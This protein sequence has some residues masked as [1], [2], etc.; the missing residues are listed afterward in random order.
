M[1]AESGPGRGSSGALLISG[2]LPTS[3]KAFSFLRGT[4]SHALFIGDHPRANAPDSKAKNRATIEPPIMVTPSQAVIAAIESAL[5]AAPE[6]H[7]LRAHLAELLLKANRPA[8]ALQ[9]ASTVLSAIPDHLGAL[10]A[11]SM[12]ATATGQGD[13]AQRYAR[14]RA[15]LEASNAAPAT[16]AP[17]DSIP[18]SPA[19]K[20]VVNEAS[21][22]EETIVRPP[23]VVPLRAVKGGTAD[24]AWRVE[25]T[26]LKL[27]DVAGLDAV[28]RRLELSLFA[29]LRHADLRRFYGQSIRGGLLLYGPPGCGKTFVARATAGE[30]GAH[31]ITFGLNDV[32][33]MFLGQ[34]EA[35]LHQ[36]FEL[37][38]RHAPCVLF[39]DEID[40]LGRKRSLQRQQPGRNLVNQLL[41]EMD[42]L[43]LNNDG[44]FVLAA[45]N[46]PWDVDTAL[47]RPGRFDR[48]IFVGPPDAAP[49]KEILAFHMRERTAEGLDLRLIAERTEGFSGADLAHL[50]DTAAELAM[51][52]SM[53]SGKIRPIQHKDFVTALKQVRP[54]TRT[55]LE[56]A[57]DYA[58][59]ANEGGAYDDLVAY[60][61]SVRMA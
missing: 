35:K 11:A 13:I 19:P 57:K 49:R 1:S 46:H 47:R 28:K 40:A 44:L 25:K 16:P 31:F 52:E 15:A 14:L 45:T 41:S 39:I 38:R 53:Q 23:K 37:A 29:Q 54:S 43:S 4:E 58:L 26:G 24:E 55:W 9:H 5:S 8:E 36:F 6:N 60:L 18:T 50:C 7:E 21:K 27:A 20:P 51:E 42:G 10:R 17:S 22:E 33:D 32:L 34:S 2:R 59:F 56:T 30:L 12:A 3:R 48:V 61:R